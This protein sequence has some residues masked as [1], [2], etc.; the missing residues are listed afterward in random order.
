[1]SKWPYD[2][3]IV[4]VIVVEKQIG[5]ISTTNFMTKDQF[6]LVSFGPWTDMDQSYVVR[7]RSID[8][9]IGNGP[10]PVPVAPF[11]HKK[12]DLTRP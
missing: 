5:C 2:D 1:M 11:G 4:Q 9:W 6:G 3:Y 8:I 12:P 10:V 7:F